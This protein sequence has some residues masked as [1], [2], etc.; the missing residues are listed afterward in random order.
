MAIYKQIDKLFDYT[1][2]NPLDPI[3]HSTR[4][5]VKV[6]TDLSLANKESLLQLS[7]NPS[8]VNFEQNKRT[9]SDV[10]QSGRVY[11]FWSSSPGEQ[12]LDILTLQISGT[13]GNILNRVA[14]REYTQTTGENVIKNPPSG[15][16][17]TKHKKWMRL[18]S[19]TRQPTYPID[20]SGAF[21]FAHIE[22][23]SPLF[24][25][26][27]TIEFKGH[28]ENPLQF[29]ERADRPFLI[30]YSFSFV[31]HETSPDLDVIIDQADKIMTLKDG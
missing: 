25:E 23:S 7:V 4:V 20:L 21:N 3:E 11:Y 26:G 13:S 14:F 28:F 31:V 27:R 30:D 22:Y 2:W 17:N 10:V 12:N 5:P 8:S 9:T 15:V 18:Y 24:P 1:L 29:E 16:I 6:W 19:M